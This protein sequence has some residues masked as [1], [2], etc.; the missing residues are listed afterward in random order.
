MLS[1]MRSCVPG[2][3]PVGLS[4]LLPVFRSGHLGPAETPIPCPVAPAPLLKV[5]ALAGLSIRCCWELR[6]PVA[7]MVWSVR[8]LGRL[9]VHL[10]F[11][12]GAFNP[13]AVTYSLSSAKAP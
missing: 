1:S 13:M 2:G 3:L 9:D 10:S 8:I 7:Q 12:V 6:L 5:A 4:G 11:R